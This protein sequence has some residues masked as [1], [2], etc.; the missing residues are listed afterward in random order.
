MDLVPGILAR[1][2]DR[3]ALS[4][5]LHF[6][7]ATAGER[8]QLDRSRAN[9]LRALDLP[10]S[11]DALELDA[12]AG[13][14]TRYLGETVNEVHALERDPE[15][16]G[17]ARSRC[18][19]L[20]NVRLAAE[21]PGTPRH[22][23]YDLVF[24]LGESGSDVVDSPGHL[25]TLRER[26]RPGGQLCV[27]FDCPEHPQ[28]S[29]TCTCL[30]VT[31]ARENLAAAGLT[32]VRALHCAP[33]LWFSRA[34]T[35]T[36]LPARYPHLA[37][38]LSSP[39]R[40][41]Q[42]D[43]STAGSPQAINREGLLLIAGD[44][45]GSA[46]QH[47][48]WSPD[49]LASYFNTT[50]RA[51]RWCTRADVVRSG[52]DAAEVRR[53]PLGPTP[54]PV[55]G[56]AVRPCTDPLRN[57]PT[58]L[59]VL[60]EQPWRARELLMS[61]QTLLTGHAANVGNA[62]WDLVPHNV[63]VDGDQLHPIDL[64]WEHATADVAA[65]TARGVLVLAQYLSAAGWSGAG[66]GSTTRDLANW[67]GALVGLRPHAIDSAVERETRFAAIGASGDL[68]GTAALR[69]EIRDTWHQRLDSNV[70]THPGP[71]GL[72][73]ATCVRRASSIEEL[74][75]ADRALYTEQ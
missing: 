36:D 49:K 41:V 19:D 67:L 18:A 28:L 9:I 44:A 53:A 39:I 46:G 68:S 73:E 74:N 16:L 38:A 71:D 51:A 12:G 63:L 27:A 65:V 25:D 59:D 75:T 1:A 6:A 45:S 21:S 11:A 40:S 52:D 10:A 70:A 58:M 4:D 34:V 47:P 8:Y 32:V 35:V 15:L 60:L 2:A 3:S 57:A 62:L 26:L 69:A 54:A 37:H 13:A 61:W 42:P 48:A 56:V 31:A 22:A 7:A 33:D 55:G 17:R 23:T 29:A 50:H 20:P 66:A 64:E 43:R 72:R 30:R 5:E 24:A 14:L